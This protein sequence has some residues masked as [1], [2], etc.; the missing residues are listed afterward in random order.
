[1]LERGLV[2]RKSA[3]AKLAWI[4]M[5][6]RHNLKNASA[7]HV[8]SQREESEARSFGLPLPPIVVVPNGVDLK[9][10]INSQATPSLQVCELIDRG[11]YLLFLGRIN[12]K[13]GLDRLIV[14]LRQAPS[15]HLVV[16]GNDEDNYRPI[17][18]ALAKSQGVIER[19]VFA[20][21]VHGAD[22]AAL[23]QHA[24]ALVLPSYSENFG[25]V[26]LEAMA[27]ACPVIV[28][29][30]VG[31]SNIVQETGSGLVVPGEPEI[32]G[33]GIADILGNPRKLRQM[34][35]LGR[36]AVER[37]FS[38]DAIAQQMESA[39]LKIL[40]GAC[41]VSAASRSQSRD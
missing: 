36:S 3:W 27:A 19:I 31:A 11:P 8:T 22:K 23:L 1:M 17:L 30:E 12:W 37:A 10:P 25:N 35:E 33:A 7:L 4:M 18:D 41:A 21:P 26:V 6:E 28:T 39:Y 16:A 14:S 13:K 5:V 2:R 9:I 40:E 24:Q 32:L 15:V 20:G 29:P 34:G 38:W